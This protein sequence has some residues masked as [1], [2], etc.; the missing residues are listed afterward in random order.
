MPVNSDDKQLIQEMLGLQRRL[1][2]F[3]FGMCQSSSD[4]EDIVQTAYER[5]ISR[6]HQWQRGTRLDNWMY[7]IVRSIAL[8]HLRAG[9]LRGER[10]TRVEPDDTHDLGTISPPDAVE[11]NAV[12]V[13]VRKLPVEQREAVL[14]VTVEGMSYREAAG[15]LGVT[16]AA[17]TS[18][19]SRGRLMLARILSGKQSRDSAAIINLR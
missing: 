3:A 19:L 11:F 5:A 6:L 10:L 9:R 1:R 7:S 13:A 8:N 15:V 16:E 12:A 4:A 17:L 14:L 18:R 2:R